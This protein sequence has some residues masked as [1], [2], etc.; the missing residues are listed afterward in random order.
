MK[1]PYCQT[2]K[3]S[4]FLTDLGFDGYGPRWKSKQCNS[5]KSIDF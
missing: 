2:E 1:C 3:E 4:G 5:G